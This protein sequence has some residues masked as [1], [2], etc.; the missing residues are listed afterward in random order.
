[1]YRLFCNHCNFCC[2]K[3]NDILVHITSQHQDIQLIC[4]V[5]NCITVRNSIKSMRNHLRHSHPQFYPLIEHDVIFSKE[6]IFRSFVSTNTI[7]DQINNVDLDQTNNVDEDQNCNIQV[8]NDHFNDVTAEVV[9]EY[10]EMLLSNGV[11]FSIPFKALRCLSLKSIEFFDSLNSQNLFSRDIIHEMKFSINSPENFDN[12]LSKNFNAVFPETVNIANTDFNFIYFPFK[13]KITAAISKYDCFE[14]ICGREISNHIRSFFSSFSNIHDNTVYIEIYID[15]FQLANP[16]LKKKS[17]KNSI[18]GIYFRILS[19]DP[20]SFSKKRNI[21]LLAL[22]YTNVFK[23]C[24]TPILKFLSEEINPY[25][26]NSFVANIGSKTK[27]LKIQIAFFC[28]DSKEASFL[29]GI[30]YG[31]SH[32]DC[33]RFCTTDRSNFRTIFTGEI[34]KTQIWYN[35]NLPSLTDLDSENHISGLQRLSPIRFFKCENFFESFPPCIDHDIFEGLVPKI[36]IFALNYFKNT[37]K[38]NFIEFKNFVKRFRFKGKDKKNFP[39]IFFDRIDQIRFTSSEGYTFI[40]F[41]CYFLQDVETDDPVFRIIDLLNKITLILM[42]QRISEDMLCILNTLVVSFLK[43]CSNF[44]ELSITVKFHHLLH[45]IDNILKFGPPKVFRTI[46]FESIHSDLK[47]M[48]RTSKNWI[49]VCY[50]IGTKFARLE[51]CPSNESAKEIGLVMNN[52]QL[53][54]PL[55]NMQN[56]TIFHLSGLVVSNQ[57]YYPGRNGILIFQDSGNCNFLAIEN[58]FK[59]NE[60]YFLHGS[61][62][63]L[64][65]SDFNTYLLTRTDHK[66]SYMIGTLS[67]SDIS[68]EI[69]QNYSERFIIPYSWIE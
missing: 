54:D 19:K 59:I 60:N 7:S 53:P 37:K 40:R 24:S 41:F 35:Q 49:D 11:K 10:I 9:K 17:Q 15:D 38:I 47:Q 61:L 2:L 58:I 20:K 67:D 36:T 48:I 25:I 21:H 30:K 6:S 32:E 56:E 50:T 14:D 66:T 31:F 45:Y 63:I 4:G 57:N 16:L 8:D 68:Y 12:Y 34:P 18:T 55:L 27:F 29:L 44:K 1:M 69:Y 43:L 39:S 23:N 26:E 22:C 3:P 33:C 13:Q 46:N 28:T 64:T 62:Y 42:S 52:L 5:E 51:V 65:L